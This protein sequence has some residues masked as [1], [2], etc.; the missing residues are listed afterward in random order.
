MGSYIMLFTHGKLLRQP[1]VSNGCCIIQFRHISHH[2]IWLT[3]CRILSLQEELKTALSPL[4][5]KLEVFN[6][7]KVICDQ[8]PGH[9]KV[10]I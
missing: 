8:T 1:P 4:E 9:I 6:E 5:E 10:Q 3:V 2:N 7:V